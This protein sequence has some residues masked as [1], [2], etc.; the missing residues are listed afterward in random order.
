MP[1]PIKIIAC[2][3]GVGKRYY[4]EKHPECYGA[5]M[6]VFQGD[7][8]SH[9]TDAKSND[10]I[11]RYIGNILQAMQSNKYRVILVSD[12]TILGPMRQL[13][14]DFTVVYPNIDL[15]EEYMERYREREPFGLDIQTV[16]DNWNDWITSLEATSYRKRRLTSGQFLADV[17]EEL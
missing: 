12:N 6:L 4:Q 15:K 1:E 5:E 8:F 10:Y 2:F 17:M 14:L 3:P 11:S 13:R 9:S 7:A 16:S